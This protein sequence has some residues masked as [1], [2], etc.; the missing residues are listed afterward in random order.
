MYISFIYVYL[1]TQHGGGLRIP[2]PYV[3]R[4]RAQLMNPLTDSPQILFEELVRI[5]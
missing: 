2:F 1:P 4:V 5:L 3:P